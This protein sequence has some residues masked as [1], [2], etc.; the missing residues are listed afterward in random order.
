M[1]YPTKVQLINRKASQQWYIN[2]PAFVAQAMDF[3]RGEVVEWVVEDRNAL[4]LKRSD[5]APVLELKKNGRRAPRA[6]RRPPRRAGCA[7]GQDV[8]SHDRCIGK[9]NHRCANPCVALH[10]GFSCGARG[11]MCLFQAILGKGSKQQLFEMSLNRRIDDTEVVEREVRAWQEHGN[12][13]NVKVNW[14]FTT[15]D[16][17]MKLSRLRPPLEG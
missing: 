4:V 17:R 15:G 9:H 1:G 2:F 5:V 7:F 8:I 13:K 11:E 3:R 16:A 10:S 14:Q 12:N 6:L